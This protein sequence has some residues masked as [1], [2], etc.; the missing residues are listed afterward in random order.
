MKSTRQIVGVDIEN[1][2]RTPTPTTESAASEAAELTEVLRLAP[3][4]VV[5][6]SGNPQN[7]QACEAAASILGGSVECQRGSNGADLVINSKIAFACY[8][9][10]RTGD[11]PFGVV[12]IVSGDGIFA[13][14]AAWVKL[15]G[16]RVRFVA[17]KETLH[18]S[19]L[20]IADQVTFLDS[21]TTLSATRK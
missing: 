16:I 13:A 21:R 2:T 11:L 19:I 15:H 14:T 17:H 3:D 1:L 5:I 7:R 8:W 9:N 10:A 18:K 20:D 6:V 4:D 12:T